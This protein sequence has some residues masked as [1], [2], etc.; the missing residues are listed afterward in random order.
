MKCSLHIF[1]H[2]YTRIRIN[3]CVGLQSHNLFSHFNSG[4]DR[5]THKF[6]T[7]CAFV[8]KSQLKF[9]CLE[10]FEYLTALIKKMDAFWVVAACSQVNV[11]KLFSGPR[12]F[13]QE[14]VTKLPFRPGNRKEGMLLKQS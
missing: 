4:F 5:S 9:C 10:G 3:M 7:N 13:H 11:H 14:N 6:A 8:S 1:L 12:P 2:V